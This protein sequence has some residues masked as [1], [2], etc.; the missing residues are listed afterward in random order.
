MKLHCRQIACS[1]ATWITYGWKLAGN[2]EE[3]SDAPTSCIKKLVKSE[4]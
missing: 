2:A 3:D 1:E 4:G